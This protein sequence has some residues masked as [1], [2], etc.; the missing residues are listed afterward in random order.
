MKRL[1]TK[2]VIV[3]AVMAIVAAACGDDDQP[4]APPA[5]T[6]APTPTDPPVT[7]PPRV[8]LVMQLTWVPQS[9]FAGYI[10]A[11]RKGF[12]DDENLDVDVLPGGPDVG[13]DQ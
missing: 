10:M 4:T 5:P 1:G 8:S 7:Q 12:Y 9:Q 13:P 2:L 6:A 3:L 11:D